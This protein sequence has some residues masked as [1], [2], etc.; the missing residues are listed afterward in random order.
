MECGKS[1][2]ASKSKNLGLDL[3]YIDSR[4][5]ALASPNLTKI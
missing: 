5:L 3:Y 2:A 1:R 4:Y